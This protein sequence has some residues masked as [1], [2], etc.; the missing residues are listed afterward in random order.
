MRPGRLFRETII[1]SGPTYL[2]SI[3]RKYLVIRNTAGSGRSPHGG[4][5][6]C[7]FPG[8]SGSVGARRVSP[9]LPLLPRKLLQSHIGRSSSIRP[10]PTLRRL[11]RRAVVFAGSFE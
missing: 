4:L 6:F 9:P 3:L 2:R 7:H 11:L 1:T 10:R 8:A 5:H